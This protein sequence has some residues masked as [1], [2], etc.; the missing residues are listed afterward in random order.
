MIENFIVVITSPIAL[1]VLLFVFLGIS[2]VVLG[3]SGD[4]GLGGLGT[5][6]ASGVA[7]FLLAVL[8]VSLFDIAVSCRLLVDNNLLQSEFITIIFYALLQ[9]ASKYIRE[10]DVG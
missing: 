6:A 5:H 4:F 7:V 8:G 10:F 3:T 9:Q 1:F 2:A